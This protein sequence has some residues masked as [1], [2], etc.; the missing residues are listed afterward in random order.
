MKKKLASFLILALTAIFAVV[1]SS[2]LA[3][4]NNTSVVNSGDDAEIR[5]NAH[6]STDINVNNNNSAFVEQMVISKSNTGGNSASGNI[7]GS[8]TINT[9][10]AQ[11]NTNMTTDVNRNVTA[12]SGLNMNNIN[13][14]DI[15]NTGDDVEVGSNTDTHT[16]IGVN[17]QN[18]ATI[19]QSCGNLLMGGCEANTGNNYAN[20]NIGDASINTGAANVNTN[21]NASANNNSTLIGGNNT[22]TGVMSDT[23]LTNTGD[24]VEISSSDMS[25]VNLNVNNT[26]DSFI[27]QMLIG[28]SNSGHNR[29]NEN[30]GNTHINTGMANLAATMQALSNENVTGISG[31][32]GM[33]PEINL[34]ETV[35]TGDE[36]YLASNTDSFTHVNVN[37][38]NTTEN[39][40]TVWF[41]SKTGSNESESNIGNTNQTN[42]GLAGFNET[43]MNTNNENMTLIGGAMSNI[44]SLMQLMGI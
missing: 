11:V 8:S 19:F 16:N 21:F 20:E 32:M 40:Q 9:G 42:T 10:A 35:N 31:D 13:T 25:D 38:T 17:N 41:E 43:F 37:S 27:E 22:N 2:V 15:V 4:T 36:I 3:L 7:G 18:N 30:I 33:M 24:D 14:T 12:I 6:Q 23:V 44:L 26:N 28:E 39:C 34:S 5:S 1:P 29:S